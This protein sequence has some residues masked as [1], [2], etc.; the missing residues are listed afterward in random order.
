[1]VLNYGAIAGREDLG[2]THHLQGRV[3]FNASL[4][5]AG[6]STGFQP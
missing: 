4:V 5:V 1:M 2:V 3:S 6:E